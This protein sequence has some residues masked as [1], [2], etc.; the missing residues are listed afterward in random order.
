MSITILINCEESINIITPTILIQNSS[1]SVFEPI[2]ITVEEYVDIDNSRILADYFNWSI[3][4]AEGTIISDNFPDS[5]AIIWTP[6]EAGYFLIKVKIGYDNN[7]SITSVKE[8]EIKEG[9]T[10][11]QSKLSGNWTGHA[12]R[13][14]GPEWDLEISIDFDGYCTGTVISELPLDNPCLSIFFSGGTWYW[15]ED[16]VGIG[17]TGNSNYPCQRILIEEVDDNIGSGTVWIAMGDVVGDDP[18][19]YECYNT[20]YYFDRLSINN[21]TEE[22]SFRLMEYNADEYEI[23]Y[24]L[25]KI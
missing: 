18:V 20:I 14:F 25:T 3:E 22:L 17:C 16:Y 10:S 4:N 9:P 24:T 5:T 8:V 1:L 13:N 23:N 6:Q 2:L 19:T 7:K 12:T 21:E 15:D 11:L